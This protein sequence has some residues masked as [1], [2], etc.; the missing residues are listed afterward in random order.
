M[1]R[2]GTGFAGW[3]RFDP[4]G[5]DEPAERRDQERQHD[6]RLGIPGEREI[7]GR[8]RLGRR[9]AVAEHGRREREQDRDNG[10]GRHEEAMNGA[11]QANRGTAPA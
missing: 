7:G 9:G 5:D 4:P 1:R 2:R 8:W 11:H 3:A 6:G 10:G